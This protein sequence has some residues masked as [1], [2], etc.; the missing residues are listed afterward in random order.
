[1]GI[2]VSNGAI[3]FLEKLTS[4][5]SKNVF[6]IFHLVQLWS[7]T[8]RSPFLLKHRTVWITWHEKKEKLLEMTFGHTIYNKSSFF[9]SLKFVGISVKYKHV[10]CTWITHFER[11]LN[12]QGPC[13]HSLL[14]QI[15]NTNFV[16]EAPELEELMAGEKRWHASNNKSTSIYMISFVL[17]QPCDC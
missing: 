6:V 3:F 17:Q 8:E 10:F 15:L 12:E 11:R 4:W 16:R 2:S 13:I 14:R 5:L 7:S 9:L 1:M